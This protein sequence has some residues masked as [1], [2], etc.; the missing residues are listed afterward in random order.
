M[1]GPPGTSDAS[2]SGEA[3][4]AGGASQPGGAGRATRVLIVDDEPVI[5]NLLRETLAGDGVDCT[6]AAGG[7]AALEALREGAFDVVLVD[8]MMPKITG[9]GL[10]EG[11]RADG[12]ARVIVVSA[13]SGADDAR[14]AFD[15]GALDVVA[16]PFEPEELAALVHEVA[17]LD[18]EGA[19]RHR[20]QARRRRGV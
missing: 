1:S 4:P 13:H 6:L 20:D 18:Q 16:K 3:S 5:R 9:W 7:D 10:L 19:D 17:G 8:L 15:L 14:R 11:M 2:Q 12:R